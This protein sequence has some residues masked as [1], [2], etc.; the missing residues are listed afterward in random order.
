MAQWK[1]IDD[2]VSKRRIHRFDSAGPTGGT[3][4]PVA[5]PQLL[6]KKNYPVINGL[7]S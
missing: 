2:V 4:E 3:E 5:P 7:R 6:A 1:R